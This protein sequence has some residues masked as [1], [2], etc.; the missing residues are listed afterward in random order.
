MKEIKLKGL[1][2]TGAIAIFITVA[3]QYLL[4]RFY[5]IML[6]EKLVPF[7]QKWE[8]GL[9]RDPSDR[10][11]AYPAPWT[12]QGKTGWHTNKGIT[13]ETFEGNAQRLGYEPTA[14]NFFSMP[15]EL[16]LKI[17]KGAFMKAF[18]LDK[19]SHLPRIQAVIITWAW[20]SGVYGAEVRLAN[21]QRDHMG[22]VSNNI[23]PKQIIEN[24]RKQI[25]P[26]NEVEW[27]EKLC[28]RRLSDFKKMP[29]WNTHGTGW[30]RRLNDFRN[31][32][33]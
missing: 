24:F 1:L 4:N 25:N 2:I 17:L 10:A 22:I 26:I 13:Y 27:F 19:I 30:T 15:D 6:L 23:T 16:W 9:S 12:Y 20:G 18:P 29:T 8:G 32:F 7:I 11:S 3:A 31:T 5:N 21:F 33:A 14:D 28:D